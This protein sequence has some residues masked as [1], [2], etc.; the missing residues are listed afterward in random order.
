MT[1]LPI[2]AEHREI[3]DSLVQARKSGSALPGFPGAV[4]D[5]MA[6][7][8]AIQDRSIANW[9][10]DVAGWKVGGVPSAHVDRLGTHW[11]AGPIFARSIR[12]CDGAKPVEMPIY[13]GGFGAIEPEF[14]FELGRTRKE[15]RLFIGAEIASSPVPAIN[16]Y[17]PTAV[18]SDLG[19]NNGLLVGPEIPDW[20]NW[21]GTALIRAEIGGEIVGEKQVDN[22]DSALSSLHFLLDLAKERGLAL[23]PG[24]YV[25]SGAI[26][27]IHEDTVG[28]RSTL[29][30]GRFGVVDLVL[31]KA[32]PS[33]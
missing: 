14:V 15:D 13:D 5:T 11:L 1:I 26:T 6:D 8:Y 4:P 2:L 18:V 27:G 17:G 22:F 29:T 33:S 3:S 28:A 12:H 19:N 23:P 20:Q 21:T 24:T 25:S 32:E 10:D 9:G 7:A 30:F 31:T 16:D